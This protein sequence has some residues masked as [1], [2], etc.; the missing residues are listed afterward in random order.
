LRHRYVLYGY[1]TQARPLAQSQYAALTDKRKGKSPF[2]N[3]NNDDEAQSKLADWTRRCDSPLDPH[4]SEVEMM[5]GT[6][7]NPSTDSLMATSNEQGEAT[8]GHS[9]IAPASREYVEIRPG[10][11]AIA[12]F[13]EECDDEARPITPKHILSARLGNAS[14][15]Q[16]DSVNDSTLIEPLIME[17]KPWC[18]L[19]YLLSTGWNQDRDSVPVLLRE[20]SVPIKMW[21]STFDGAA[22]HRQEAFMIIQKLQWT[23]KIILSLL[24]ISITC[25]LLFLC[26]LG[27]TDNERLIF[28]S[29]SILPVPTLAMAVTGRVGARLMMKWRDNNENWSEF[30]ESQRE[31]YSN[32]GIT[33]RMVKVRPA[34]L[35]PDGRRKLLIGYLYFQ[36]ASSDPATILN[37]SVNHATDEQR[38]HVV[39]ELV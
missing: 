30:V 36:C 34:M 27:A 33:V 3:G 35:N 11:V 28:T 16:E 32:Y 14:T 21:Q 25:F 9:S 24:F 4:S 20:K 39:L 1:F 38:T 22:G 13:D 26:I 15:Q 8:E 19:V 5:Q 23:R 10:A 2:I 29:L 7:S 12:G 31:M 6:N 37:I 18:T 17:E